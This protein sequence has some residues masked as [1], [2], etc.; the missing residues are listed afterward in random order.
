M[1]ETIIEPAAAPRPRRQNWIQKLAQNPVMVKELRGRMRGGRAFI[2]ISIYL[3]ML[4]CLVGFIYF[5]YASSNNVM[6]TNVRQTMGK[7]VFWAVAALE[8]ML[9]CFIAPALTAGAIASEREH[10]TFDLLRTTLLPARDLVLG[11]LLSALSFLFLLLVAA[12]PIQSMATLFGGVIVEEILI[13]FLLLAVSSIFFSCLGL[14]FSSLMKRT[15]APTVLAYAGTLLMVFGSPMI[16][17]T[18][19]GI[20]SQFVV[21][22]GMNNPLAT[23]IL[24]TIGWFLVATNPLGAG[25]GTEVILLQ[26][27]S[28]FFTTIPLGNGWNFPV[29]SPWIGF[30]IFYLIASLVFLLASIRLIRRAEG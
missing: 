21:N 29:V 30:V 10:Q 7:T 3:A 13:A 23:G 2:L 1:T 5:G 4:S 6:G 12:F 22:P 28:L 14:F 25:V 27:Q 18:G 26:Q 9:V 11:K 19:L 24:Y 17:F 16:I 15:L 8:L 20:F